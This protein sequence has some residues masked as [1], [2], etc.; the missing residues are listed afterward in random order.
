MDLVVRGGFEIKCAAIGP[1]GGNQA[2]NRRACVEA[3]RREGSGISSTSDARQKRK[4][5]TWDA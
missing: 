3:N 5:K 2:A 1:L 4:S